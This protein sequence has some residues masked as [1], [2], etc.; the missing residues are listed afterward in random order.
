MSAKNIQACLPGT[1]GADSGVA[2]SL[3]SA[4][5]SSRSPIVCD[6]K[7]IITTRHQ[8][9]HLINHH[10]YD[11]FSCSECHVMQQVGSN[12]YQDKSPA[13]SLWQSLMSADLTPD[14]MGL[15]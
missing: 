11:N 2:F 7:S 8:V 9:Q 3:T 12:E 14:R 4:I 13:T 5:K 15:T 6:I 1:G 10:Y